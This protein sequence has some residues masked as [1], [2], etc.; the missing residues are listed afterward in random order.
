MFNFGVYRLLSE[1]LS[2][3]RRISR[4][5]YATNTG[6]MVAELVSQSVSQ[7]VS[8]PILSPMNPMYTFTPYFSEIHFNI[9]LPFTPGSSKCLFT[10]KTYR[11]KI[12]VNL[13]SL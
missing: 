3:S 4:Q 2:Y 8:V 11:K 13:L 10:F 12:S 5:V 7:S 1:N 6:A 9:I